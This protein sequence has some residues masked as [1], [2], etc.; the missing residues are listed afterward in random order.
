MY[1][2]FLFVLL[3]Q[4]LSHIDLVYHGTTAQVYDWDCALACADTILEWTGISPSEDIL[5]EIIK[6]KRSISFRHLQ[7][8]LQRHGL[9]SQGYR[10]EWEH[11]T[12]FLTEN[13]GNPLLVHLEENGGHF[14]LAI[15]MTPTGVVTSDPAHGVHV[16]PA[17]DFQV[18]WS[19]NVL[20][21]PGLEP[22]PKALEV[23]RTT[24]QRCE[25]LERAR[26]LRPPSF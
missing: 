18:V 10:L 20:Y 5:L 9:P 12:H 26:R 7:E 8:Y 4:S 3:G 11:F 15:G 17:S 6:P 19:G 22:L 14:V 23:L 25:L 16:I 21:F 2:M 24:V 1:L 13:P